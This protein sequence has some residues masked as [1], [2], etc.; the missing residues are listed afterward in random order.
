MTTTHRATL[1][2]VLT[3][4]AVACHAATAVASPLSDKVQQA[5]I[6]KSRIAALDQRLHSA[7]ARYSAAAARM[8]KADGAVASNARKLDDLLGS[9]DQLQSHLDVRAAFMYRTG[10]LGFL[11]VLMGSRT[12]S[13]FSSRWDLL[14]QLSSDDAVTIGRLKAVRS[15]ALAEG[16][17]LIARQADSARELRILSAS[18]AAIQA[19]LAQRRALLAS[20]QG[21]IRSLESAQARRDAAAAASAVAKPPSD[22]YSGATASGGW[23]S[24]MASWYGP[25]FYGSHMADGETLKPDS[26]I[27]A[28]KTLRF[29]TLIEF[30]FKGH[31]AVAKVADRGPFVAGR[32]FD[33]GPG[34]A[35]VLH[36]DGV[37][38]VRY[39]I[40]GR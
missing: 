23:S 7:A 24:G 33:L 39:R 34:T 13:E 4:L 27:V 35:R 15:Q 1:V 22:P 17:T 18:R 10:A 2:A 12:F 36:F 16:R 37:A 40:I 30:M 3:I 6:A 21:D 25:G 29:G 11:E 26:M 9:V 14:V 28:H 19:Q 31:R 20:V 5:A 38:R 8:S 32:E